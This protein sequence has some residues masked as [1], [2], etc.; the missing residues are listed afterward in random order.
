ME[1]IPVN[2]GNCLISYAD[3]YRIITHNAYMKFTAQINQFPSNRY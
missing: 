1:V 3:N 2:R